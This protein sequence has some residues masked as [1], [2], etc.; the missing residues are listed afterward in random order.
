MTKEAQKQI[1]SLCTGELK[2]EGFDVDTVDVFVPYDQ[3]SV[4]V[5]VDGKTTDEQVESFIEGI[6]RVLQDMIDHINDVKL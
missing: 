4:T 3:A 5:E 2:V 6:N 1:R